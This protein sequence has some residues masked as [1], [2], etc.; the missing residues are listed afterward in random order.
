MMFS[1]ALSL[2][3]NLA[4]RL[5][6]AVLNVVGHVPESELSASDTPA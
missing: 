6:D 5:A 3:K 4:Q 2:R 1:R